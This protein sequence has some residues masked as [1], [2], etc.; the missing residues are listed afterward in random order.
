M[1]IRTKLRFILRGTLAIHYG[2]AEGCPPRKTSEVSEDFGSLGQTPDP[3]P[4]RRP[5][6]VPLVSQTWREALRPWLAPAVV[7][8]VAWL[9][10]VPCLDPGGSYP[11]WP[12]G[13]GLTVDEIFNVQQGVYLAEAVRTYHV[14]LLEPDV[15]REVFSPP[16]HLPDHPPLGRLWLG[17]HHQLMWWLCP[18][19][20][21]DGPFVVACARS[22]SAT[23]FAL[24]ILLVGGFTSLWTSR[25]AGLMAALAL[26]LLPRA[27]G[28]AHLAA[29][30]TCM[31]LAF[32]ATALTA[33]HTW[34]RE[35]PPMWQTAAWTGAIFGLALLTKIQAVFLPIP[36]AAWALYH[37]RVRAVRPLLIW[38]GVGFLVFFVGWPWLWFDPV[39]HLKTYFA[40]TTDRT[41]ISVWFLGHQS[42]DRTVTRLYALATLF[43][44]VPIKYA[45]LGGLDDIRRLPSWLAKRTAAA[46]PLARFWT[47]RETLVLL[48]LL[49]PLAVF[50]LPGVPI[51]DAERLWFPAVP[52]GAVFLGRGCH[53][54]RQRAQE[55]FPRFG[56]FVGAVLWATM[57]TQV[58]SL[59]TIA[60]VY[61][62]H[63][64][65]W[66]LGLPGAKSRGQELNYWGDAVARELLQRVVEQTPRG[67]TI[68]VSPVLHQ[69]QV[70][71]LWRQSPIL[72]AHGVRLVP[73]ESRDTAEYVLLFRRL[74]DLPEELRNGPDD[75]ELL[76]EVSRHGV[77]LAA[78]YRWQ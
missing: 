11:A 42:T 45:V 44:V 62:S 60:P 73:Y 31:G 10:V 15:L 24:T 1:R 13:P 66:V 67:A 23:A 74:A 30:E 49:F 61:L 22:G 71:E 51:Y 70:E 57:L 3:A 50:S 75:A 47:P 2:R 6:A 56:P 65:G 4:P 58:W 26:A 29:L 18:P 52:L 59:G 46:P 7:A 37:W 5:T 33:A 41:A 8:C 63:Y 9:S 14:G 25:C 16:M 40:G 54:L 21:P 78:L 39:G 35:S 28:H 12:A 53:L 19:H 77:Q 69:F 32:T 48:Q 72:R 43:W 36:L 68:A 76:A 64:S 17:V 34:S 20:D 27:Y 38:G 55:S